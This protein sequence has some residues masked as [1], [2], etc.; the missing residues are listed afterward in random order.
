[1]LGNAPEG[2]DT[3]S[4]IVGGWLSIAFTALKE[5][6]E[7]S[8]VSCSTDDIGDEAHLIPLSCLA[9]K[10]PGSE[11]YKTLELICLT[12][13]IKEDVSWRFCQPK[14]SS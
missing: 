14:A 13:G 1:M 7:P 11:L 6:L 8:E 10:P 3:N 9:A 5:S 2:L 12:T 4:D